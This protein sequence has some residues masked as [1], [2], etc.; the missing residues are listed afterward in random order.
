MGLLFR[1]AATV[2]GECL[3]A[4]PNAGC[5]ECGGTVLGGTVTRYGARFCSSRNMAADVWKQTVYDELG[6]IED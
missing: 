4:G 1:L 2:S 5:R 3:P 6:N